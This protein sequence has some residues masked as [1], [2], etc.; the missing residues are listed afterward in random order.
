MCQSLASGIAKISTGGLHQKLKDKIT[1]SD[2]LARALG[3][4][5]LADPLGDFKYRM[6]GK[7]SPLEIRQNKLRDQRAQAETDARNKDYRTAAH[8]L[9]IRRATGEG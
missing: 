7:K 1:V 3:Y 6:A 4:E 9:N 2:P 8:T 5:G